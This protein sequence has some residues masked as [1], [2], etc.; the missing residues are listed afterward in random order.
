MKKIIID[1]FDSRSIQTAIKEL[2]KE[3]SIIQQKTN[4]LNERLAN[5]G[6]LK[7]EAIYGEA[8]YDGDNDVTV[9]TEKTASGWL[10]VAEGQAVAFIEFGAGI[11]YNADGSYPLTKPE[12]IV[13][14]GEYG[15]GWGKR[16][17]WVFKTA[18]GSHVFTRGTPMAMPLYHAGKEV[19][20]K[21]LSVAREIFGGNI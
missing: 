3:K 5:I 10:I 16:R 9:G 11:Y 4:E 13:G 17:G 2:E 18:S 19:R 21:T 8:L 6:L 12:G 14:I 15:K 20:E 1:P 7:A